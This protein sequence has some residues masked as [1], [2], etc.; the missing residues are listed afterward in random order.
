MEM[1]VEAIAFTP[2][3]DDGKAG[4][5][6]EPH[7]EQDIHVARL[8]AKRGEEG[9]GME[10]SPSSCFRPFA[11]PQMANPQTQE[12]P[13]LPEHLHLIL[14]G[15]HLL[16]G[17]VGD[18]EDLDCHIPMPAAFEDCSKGSGTNALQQGYLIGRHLPI[19]AGVPVAQRFLQGMEMEAELRKRVGSPC[20][21]SRP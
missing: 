13:C 8:P 14:E 7:E 3:G 21:L 12:I 2:L 9:T 18:L 16:A 19:V 15:L 6:H 1:L 11:S 5:S 17:G 10:G 4:A 20:H